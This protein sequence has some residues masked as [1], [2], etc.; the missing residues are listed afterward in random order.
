[1]AWP[2]F[3]IINGKRAVK[4]VPTEDGGLAVLAY[5]PEQDEWAPALTLQPRLSFGD[6]DTDFVSAEEFDAFVAEQRAR[7]HGA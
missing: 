2:R 6:A 4:A 7:H 3:C 1:M 5:L